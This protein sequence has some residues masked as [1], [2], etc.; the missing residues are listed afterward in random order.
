[1]YNK[2][3][4]FSP[5]LCAL[6]RSLMNTAHFIHEKQKTVMCNGLDVHYVLMSLSGRP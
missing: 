5:T 1:V 3:C 6:F 4:V 2:V